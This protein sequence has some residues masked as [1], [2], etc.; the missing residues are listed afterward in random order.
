MVCR[1][2]GLLF[3]LQPHR[4]KPMQQK[5]STVA[6]PRCFWVFRSLLDPSCGRVLSHPV[7]HPPVFNTRLASICQGLLVNARDFL[8]TPSRFGC[9][10]NHVGSPLL[11]NCAMRLLC[12]ERFSKFHKE[13][14]PTEKG[15]FFYSDVFWK[16]I[17]R[18]FAKLMV[19][20]SP[21]RVQRV[22]RSKRPHKDRSAVKKA[23]K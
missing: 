6:Y 22:I 9:K 12:C 7:R 4:L 21:Q 17:R 5:S 10:R 23:L 15:S 18:V 20:P 13:L 2:P 8:K 1:L 14:N 3:R 16:E 19:S 11:I